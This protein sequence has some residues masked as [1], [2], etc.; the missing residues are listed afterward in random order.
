MFRSRLGKCISGVGAAAVFALVSGASE[1]RSGFHVLYAFKGGSD[2]ATPEAGLVFDRAG[3]LYGTTYYGGAKKQGTVFRLS[4]DGTETVLYAFDWNYGAYPQ[5]SLVLDKAGNL[6]G[7]TVNGGGPGVGTIFELTPGG[8]ETVLYEFMGS[9]DGGYP[10]SGLLE[11][12]AGNLYGTNPGFYCDTPCGA[13]Y[14]LAPD[15]TLTVLHTFSYTGKGGA[16]AFAVPIAD[17][18]GNLYGTATSGGDSTCA[19]GVVFAVTPRGREKVLHTFAG[20]PDD[21][22]DPIAGVIA[23]SSG[24]LYGTTSS[25][26]AQDMGSVFELKPDGTLT[27]L[28]SFAGT[29]GNYP[30]AALVADASGNLYGTTMDG[31]AQ[32]LGVV[33]RLAVDGTETIL[34][35]FEGGKDG[36]NPVANLIPDSKGN[37]FG[38]ANSGGAHGNGVVFEIEN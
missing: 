37:L 23:D 5:A 7:T 27:L 31:G 38:T 17:R 24:N 25:G 10:A 14:K 8:T 1:A 4:P 35:T 29:D 34:H 9:N 11:D 15:G 36:A 18:K 19:C 30:A 22:G 2:G 28:H 13:V 21:G 3:N 6:F 12:K 26:G 20:A 16:I 33:F 32:N